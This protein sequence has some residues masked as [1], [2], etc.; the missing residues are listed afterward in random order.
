MNSP[1]YLTLNDIGKK[2]W[3]CSIESRLERYGVDPS[4][5]EISFDDYHIDVNLI[6]KALKLQES[7]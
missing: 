5:L 7:K 1:K 6:V 4:E 3:G 2:N